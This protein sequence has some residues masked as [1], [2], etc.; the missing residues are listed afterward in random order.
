MTPKG[1][2]PFTSKIWVG[3]DSGLP[4]RIVVEYQNGVLKTMTVNYDTETPV[5]IEAPKV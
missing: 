2:Y 4:M 3:K 5:T 1:G